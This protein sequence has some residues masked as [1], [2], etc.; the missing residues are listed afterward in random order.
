MTSTSRT[1]DAVTH[2]VNSI[3]QE[4]FN[5]H[6]NN[7]YF[8]FVNVGFNENFVFFKGVD[9]TDYYFQIPERV[10]LC[11][12]YK[13]IVLGESREEYPFVIRGYKYHPWNKFRVYPE[14][15]IPIGANISFEIDYKR[16]IHEIQELD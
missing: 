5:T 1:R 13:V 16:K 8:R 14:G 2:T 7:F 11:N 4:S 12:M 6:R 9:G 10:K 15:T 3:S